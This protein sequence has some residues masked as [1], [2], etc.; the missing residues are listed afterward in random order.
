[1]LKLYV[2]CAASFSF[3][4][5]SFSCCYCCCYHRCLHR[6]GRRLRCS[7]CLSF[8]RCCLIFAF[9]HL[10]SSL[11]SSCLLYVFVYIALAFYHGAVSVCICE[12]TFYTRTH[13]DSHT[14]RTYVDDSGHL[15]ALHK[16][17][18]YSKLV[19]GNILL[20]LQTNIEFLRFSVFG[21]RN[22]TEKNHTHTLC[23]ASCKKAN[24][25]GKKLQ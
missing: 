5:F 13:M 6:C 21:R 15:F 20:H 24:E 2:R 10:P 14:Y 8:F 18:P 25:R 19:V 22:A 11:I 9:Q 7:C 23:D 16:C 12:C 1:M 17:K 3:L 4:S